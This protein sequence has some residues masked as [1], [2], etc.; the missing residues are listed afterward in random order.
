MVGL[1]LQKQQN[2]KGVIQIHPS[3]PLILAFSKVSSFH[4]CQSI[5]Y[6]YAAFES[7]NP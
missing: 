6:V 2:K 4:G 1:L 7:L 5:G 3:Y